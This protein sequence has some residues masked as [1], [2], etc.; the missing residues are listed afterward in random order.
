M[1]AQSASYLSP[2]C[3][4]AEDAGKGGYRIVA[5][6]PITKGEVVCIWGGLVVNAEQLAA[7][8]PKALEH[9]L[10]I[11]EGFYLTSLTLDEPPSYFNHSCA[12]NCGFDGQIVLV[13][14]RDIAPG[15]EVTFDYA[16]CD[17]SPYDEFICR[18]G[19]GNCRGK[20][21]GSDWRTPEL[22][23]RY[24]GYF[25]PYLQRRIAHLAEMRA[26]AAS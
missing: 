9:T 16:M 17:S 5:A 26:S 10:Q 25:S 7:L 4:V 1:P 6:A 14:M 12:P 13:A 22:R 15:E 11:E 2:N 3:C 23:D 20:V 24:A 18:C 21:T 19:A 8:P